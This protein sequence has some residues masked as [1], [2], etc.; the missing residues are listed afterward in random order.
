MSIDSAVISFS[1][2]FILA[3][4]GLGWYINQYFYLLPVFAGINLFQSG[5]TG[6][7]PAAMVFRFMGLSPGR[8]FYKS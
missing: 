6:F 4:M 5:F 7:C 1:G 8:A 2:L 3:G